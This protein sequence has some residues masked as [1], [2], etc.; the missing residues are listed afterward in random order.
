MNVLMF[1]GLGLLFLVAGLLEALGIVMVVKF[2]QFRNRA[3][4]SFK[5]PE[6][7]ARAR[8]EKHPERFGDKLEP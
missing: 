5:T 4:K 1:A 2:F 7:I 6:Q 3:L 8:H